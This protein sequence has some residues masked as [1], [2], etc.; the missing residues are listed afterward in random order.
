[1]NYLLAIETS[2]KFGSVAIASRTEES[3]QAIVSLDL[4]KTIGSAQSL[5]PCIEQIA[6]THGMPL[7][8]LG[9]IALVN[10]PGS[11]T[12]LRVGVATAKSLAYALRVPVVPLDTLDVVHLQ[13]AN[14]ALLAQRT[15]PPKHIHALLDAYRGQLFVQSRSIRS[16]LSNTGVLDIEDFLRECRESN[17]SPQAHALIGPGCQRV[18]RF[19]ERELEDAELKGWCEQLPCFESTDFEPHAVFV[20]KLGLER[21]NQGR[22]ID[23]FLLLPNY[24][25]GSAAE[26]KAKAL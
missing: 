4:P 20:A 12:G 7:S 9:C 17:D 21:W 11:F 13:G 23:P 25:R 22:Q 14:A 19:C 6:A 5:A 24:F 3:S 16:S 18:L 26:E 15:D 1:M 10:G 2:G 8:E